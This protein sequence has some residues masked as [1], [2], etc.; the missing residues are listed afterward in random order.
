MSREYDLYLQ[1]HCSNVAKGFY[2]IEENLPH[3][4]ERVKMLSD[5]DVDLVH[6]ICF[7]HD[8]SKS[9]PEEYAAYDRYFYGGAAGKSY[10]GVLAFKHAWL[11]H[12]HHNPHHWQH[13]ILINDDPNEGEVILDMPLNYI[14]EMICDFWSFSWKSGNLYEIFEW[15]DKHKDYMKLSDK[16]RKHVED[17]L[18]SI[19]EKLE[20]K[21]EIER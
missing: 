8:Y 11:R 6:Q 9:D 15:Y 2:W 10:A 14:L 16:T 1:Q 12:I 7:A 4:I 21:K 19:K 20:E 5:D 18:L 3:V 17:I 13:W